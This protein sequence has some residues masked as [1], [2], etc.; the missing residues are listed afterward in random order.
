M[1]VQ[2]E[3]QHEEAQG[4]LSAHED[5]SSILQFDFQD[6]FH[7]QSRMETTL[8]VVIAITHQNYW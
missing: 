5:S 1:W 4:T 2:S 3:T 8:T 6:L 7:I